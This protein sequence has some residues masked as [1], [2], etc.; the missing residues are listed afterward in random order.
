LRAIRNAIGRALR[1]LC[2]A[3]QHLFVILQSLEPALDVGC[4]VRF[5]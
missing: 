2:G 3:Y 5:Y 4:M 1:F